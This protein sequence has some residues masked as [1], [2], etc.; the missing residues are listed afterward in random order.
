MVESQENNYIRGY[1][2]GLALVAAKEIK[3]DQLSAFDDDEVKRFDQ[4]FEALFRWMN[5]Q[6]LAPLVTQAHYNAILAAAKYAKKNI[7]RD[8]PFGGDGTD[9]WGML[10]ITP[11]DVFSGVNDYCWEKNNNAVAAQWTIGA[12]VTRWSRN[13]MG[14]AQRD[15]G[16]FQA[17][18][19]MRTRD[20]NND[21]WAMAYF[22]VADL[23]GTG[24]IQG[25]AFA[26]KNKEHSWMEITP[27]ML[28]NNV[29]YADMG[30]VAYATPDAGF[31]SG[32]VIKAVTAA[33]GAAVAARIAFRPI[34][35]AFVSSTRA[36]NQAGAAAQTRPIVG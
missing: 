3:E 33:P 8:A 12:A 16:T 14:N 30:Q 7:F 27:Q 34:G 15:A 24:I 2:K 5:W 36:T 23:L 6:G 21:E 28:A 31:K 11:E 22:G 1:P 32:V 10:D 13:D 35:V 26:F 20:V 17:G 4:R 25:H 29:A 19:P 18:A 9:D